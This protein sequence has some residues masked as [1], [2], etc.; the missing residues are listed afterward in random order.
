MEHL[1][2]KNKRTLCSL[3]GFPRDGTSRW[4]NQDKPGWDVPLSLCPSVPLSRCPFV[5]G[6][7][8]NFCPVVPK[9]CTVPSCWNPYFKPQVFNPKIPTKIDTSFSRSNLKMFIF[10]FT[11]SLFQHKANLNLKKKFWKRYLKLLNTF[12]KKS[13][14]VCNISSLKLPNATH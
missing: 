9:S 3:L 10:R 7:W 8:R 2:S 6:Q 5:P 13:F 12:F 4:T 11:L 1:Q 14:K